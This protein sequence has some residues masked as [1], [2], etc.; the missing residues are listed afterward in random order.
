MKLIKEVCSRMSLSKDG[1]PLSSIGWNHVSG[2][3]EGVMAVATV[4]DYAAEVQ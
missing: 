2:P 4:E 3:M 1:R